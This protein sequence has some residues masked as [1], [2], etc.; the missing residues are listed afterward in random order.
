MTLETPAGVRQVYRWINDLSYT[1]SKGRTWS[2]SAIQCTETFPDQPP[3][4]WAWLTKWP[5]DRDNVVAIA[6]IGGRYRWHIENQG[7]NTQKNSD[8]N[9]EHA[10]SRGPQWKSYYYLLQIA[11]LL[12]QLL[13]KG[14]LLRQLAA[15][16]GRLKRG[17]S[18]RQFE[19]H[20]RTV[21]REPAVH[22]LAGGGLR[23][24]RRRGHPDSLRQ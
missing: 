10:Y 11:H 17:G 15:A 5:V 22:D 14:S 1:D 18:L 2:L 7:F 9:L 20:G 24:R 6:T 23:C 16:A 21:A 8:L 12:L 4:V 3:S 19:E 13:E